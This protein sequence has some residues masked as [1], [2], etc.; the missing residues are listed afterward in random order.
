MVGT[1]FCGARVR[2]GGGEDSGAEAALKRDKGKDCRREMVCCRGNGDGGQ[3]AGVAMA[4]A[5][6]SSWSCSSHLSSYH[7]YT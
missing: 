1:C 3:A 7:S 2:D 6:G 4:S 5:L